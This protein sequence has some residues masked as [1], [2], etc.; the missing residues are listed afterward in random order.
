MQEVYLAT[1]IKWFLNLIDDT[2]RT[3]PNYSKAKD[4]YAQLSDDLVQPVIDNIAPLAKNNITPATIKGFIFNP[5]R[6]NVD[7]IRKTYEILIKQILMLF[8]TL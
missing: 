4:V 3:N 2:L 5:E 8:Q 7:D 1:K 6:N